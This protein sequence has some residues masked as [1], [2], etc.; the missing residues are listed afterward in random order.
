MRK[1][2]H[3]DMD[4]FFASVEQRDNPSLKNRPVVVG[5]DSKR[6]VVA[7]ASYEARKYGIF[8]AMPMAL[9]KQK[10]RDLV[11]VPHRFNVYKEV[12]QQIREIF[13][14]YTDLVEPLSLDEAYLDVSKSK[15]NMQSATDIAKEIKSLVWEKT[16]LSCTAG[17]S[18]NKF[19]AKIASDMNKPDGLTVIKPNQVQR[20]VLDLPVEKFYGVGK[21]TL[22]RMHGLNVFTGA[23]LQKYSKYELTRI[24]GKSGL[25]YYDVCR[26]IDDRPVKPSRLRKSVSIERTFEE[27]VDTR[28]EAQKI[29]ITLCDKLVNTLHRLQ[30]SGRTI[31][32]KWRYPDFTT[33]TRSKSYRTF[34]NDRETIESTVLDLMNK[35]IDIEEGVRLLG[36]GMSNLDTEIE[37]E[38]LTF[39]FE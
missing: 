8:S 6:S 36:V 22:R 3:I 34:L 2:I 13:F 23:D 4:A 7:A 21:A 32:L 10:C 26:G 9:A 31:Q 14:Q 1:I 33:P 39:E 25:Y 11:I 27:D 37:E 16:S 12:S 29:L 24:F 35:H 20:F 19:L 5:G 38:Q 28:E 18:I 30:V 15:K 17:I